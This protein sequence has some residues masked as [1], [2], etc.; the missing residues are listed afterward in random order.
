[1]CVCVRSS[2]CLWCVCVCVCLCVCALAI[3]KLQIEFVLLSTTSKG[4][5]YRGIASILCDVVVLT[6]F[7]LL[8]LLF[9]HLVTILV[10][11]DLSYRHFD[12]HSR[13]RTCKHMLSNTLPL[14]SHLLGFIGASQMD[15]TRPLSPLVR[16]DGLVIMNVDDQRYWW[17]HSG[18]SCT[19]FA[20][21]RRPSNGLWVF[22]VTQ[23][24]THTH[25]HT[26]K[27][28]RTNV[29]AHT[30]THTYTCTKA[31]TRWNTEYKFSIKL[32]GGVT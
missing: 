25:T 21:G 15:K 8:R 9:Y 16:F 23:T 12:T 20:P 1:M 28:T 24:H 7:W 27:H 18:M 10:P 6:A 17:N 2:V 30:K 26:H 29:H 13:R 4:P 31:H 11:V 14:W 19:F 32:H 5:S 22:C 3:W